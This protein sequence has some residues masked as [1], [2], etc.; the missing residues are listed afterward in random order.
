ALLSGNVIG[1]DVLGA[2]GAAV[3]GPVTAVNG[4]AANVGAPVAGSYGSLSLNADGSYSYQSTP[5]SVPAGTTVTDVFQYTIT[6]GDGDTSTVTLTISIPD[7]AIETHIDT[8]VSDQTVN[9]A[10]LGVGSNPT[11]PDE[12]ASGQ[13]AA[14]GGTGPYTYTGGGSGS[15]GNLVVNP[16]GSYTYTLTSASPDVAGVEETETFTY[17]VTDSL[18]NTATQTLTITI[19]D[20]VPVA[21]NDTA[22]I[23]E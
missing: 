7:G 2:D 22:S 17:T 10:A 14:S 16:D 21:V 8:T 11:S 12:V 23:A 18:G 4:V 6:D 1:N 9:E 20:D 5:N 15:Y 13:L 19:A 3:G